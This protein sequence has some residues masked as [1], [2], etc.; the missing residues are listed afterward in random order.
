MHVS[1]AVVVVLPWVPATAEYVTTGQHVFG[2]P[3]GS[4]GERQIALQD[5]FH[6][7]I[8]PR[9]DVADHPQVGCDAD[10]VGAV[11]FDQPY[12]RRRQLIAHGRVDTCIA[13]R[14]AVARGERQLRQT[15]HEGAADAEDVDVH[16]VRN[17]AS[18][19]GS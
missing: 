18:G 15:A 6:Q 1:I 12:T 13:A 9:D 16:G 5:F 2:K 17:G 10:L 3:L 14:H 8:A 19:V 7:R 4:G 11:S